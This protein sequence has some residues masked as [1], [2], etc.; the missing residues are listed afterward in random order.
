MSASS[1][2]ETSDKVPEFVSRVDRDKKV[3]ELSKEQIIWILDWY[4]VEVPAGAKKGHLLSILIDTFKAGEMQ[5]E[6]QRFEEAVKLQEL[7]LKN[8]ELEI[9]RLKML[10]EVNEK[11]R[12]EREKE[13]EELERERGHELQV[14]KLKTLKEPGS[15]FNIASAIK[16]V[17]LFVEEDVTEFFSAFEKLAN[18]LEWP[19]QMWTTLVQCRLI[20]KA[21]KLYVTLPE[22]TCADYEQVKT[23]ILKAYEL[24]PE[25]YRQ[26]F[27]NLKKDYRETYVEFA[28]QK[29]QVFDEW[30]RAKVVDNFSKLRELI[31]L[32]EF[33]SCVSR[34]IKLYT[35]ELKIDTLS[36]AAVAADEYVLSHRNTFRFKTTGP[37]GG[38]SKGSMGGDRS[39]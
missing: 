18:K 13:R 9:Q 35:E 1:L 21:Q 14:L 26:K 33:K 5:G 28:R 24:V 11:E 19:R 7:E 22:E 20:G 32:E 23:L 15:E 34:E 12:E 3:F 16:L 6:K 37:M 36:A 29:E 27:R 38:G 2:L 30:C 39:G 25:A 10:R 4:E 17:P 31:L 8:K